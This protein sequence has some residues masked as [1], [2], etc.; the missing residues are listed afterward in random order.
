MTSATRSSSVCVEG[1]RQ[2]ADHD[3]EDKGYDG[4]RKRRA[5]K[6][7]G[8]PS[9]KRL[10]NQIDH[11]EYNAAGHGCH[12]AL[13]GGALPEAANQQCHRHAG[14]ERADNV[15]DVAHDVV[16]EDGHA[17]RAN[18][19]DDQDDTRVFRDILIRNRLF[20]DQCINVGQEGGDARDC[21]RVR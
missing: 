11:A 19:H 6:D 5:L 1:G 8:D 16:G 21:V 2:Q 13:P 12:A 14:R 9:V 3:A 18:Q 4:Y 17:E 10:V 20:E 15:V 7:L